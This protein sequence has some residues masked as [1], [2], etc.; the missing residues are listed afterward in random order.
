MILGL[1][2]SSYDTP[3]N[4]LPAKMN[5]VQ[6]AYNRITWGSTNGYVMTDTKFAGHY[7]KCVEA[8]ILVGAYHYFQS[9]L[10][11]IKQATKFIEETLKYPKIGAYFIDLEDF[12]DMSGAI[13]PSAKIS[14]RA[15]TWVDYVVTHAPP[16]PMWVYTGGW[17]VSAYARD[18]LSWILKYPLALSYY[19]SAFPRGIVSWNTI[20]EALPKFPI[21]VLGDM[22]K[23]LR[24]PELM[25]SCKIWQI[26]D[27]TKPSE[28]IDYP[29]ID[30]FYGSMEELKDLFGTEDQCEP[31]EPEEVTL[32][33]LDA[34]VTALEVEAT[35]HGWD[36]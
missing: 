8:G 7:Q 11:P 28:F 34:R 15:K 26:S 31:D 10:D 17:F 1:D 23:F 2:L 35:L 16:K 36:I 3:I 27:K 6:F 29:D 18:L 25:P 19:P 30:V 4:L 33:T 9:D 20:N 13:V 21:T 12:A 5:G 24:V 22:M 14:S 32:E